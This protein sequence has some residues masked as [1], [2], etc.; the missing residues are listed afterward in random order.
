M[1]VYSHDVTIQ[2]SKDRVVSVLTDPFL[3]TGVLGH[4]NILQVYDQK[5][6]KYVKPSSISGFSN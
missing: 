4:I 3:L 6:G 2:T 5:E 1:S